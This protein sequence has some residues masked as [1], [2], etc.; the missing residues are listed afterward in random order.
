MIY[1]KFTTEEIKDLPKEHL[2]VVL[3]I[4]AIE[5]HGP[6]LPLDTDSRIVEAIAK[7]AEEKAPDKIMLLPLLPYGVTQ[8]NYPGSITVGDQAFKQTLVEIARSVLNEGFKKIFFL[9]GHG[10][11]QSYV[12]DAVTDLNIEFPSAATIPLYLSGKRGR[13]ALRKVG[14]K[15]WI[16]HA[17]EIETSIMLF[18]DEK[19]V[20]K[21]KIIDEVGILKTSDYKPF[22]EG[23]LK[24]YLPWE[25]ETKSGVYGE[26]SKATKEIGE[27]L[28][29]EAANELIDIIIQFEKITQKIERLEL[30]RKMMEEASGN[31]NNQNNKEAQNN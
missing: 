2:V 8:P 26:P 12:E 13:Q 1:T 19:S 3:P 23:T 14:F 5:Q 16:R 30:Q 29:E 21:D 11:N 27:F 9:N 20:R 24:L 25:Y 22:D 4:G 6:H 15:Y 17:D 28:L 7:R 10:G 18:I 31:D